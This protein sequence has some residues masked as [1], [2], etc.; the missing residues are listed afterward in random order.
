MFAGPALPIVRQLVPA[1]V[2]QILLSADLGESEKFGGRRTNVGI[3]NAGTSTASAFVELRRGCDDRL[4]DRRLISVPAK[5]II[6]VAGPSFSPDTVPGC[7][8]L[9]TTAS[10][11]YAVINADQPTF[12]YIAVL[13]NQLP[14]IT[15]FTFSFVR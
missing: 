15:P 12:S 11:N 14:P 1:G 8:A 3:Y 6:Q 2:P 4:L 5:T 9:N 10:V 7:T 13:A